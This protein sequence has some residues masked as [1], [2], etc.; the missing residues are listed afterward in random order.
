MCLLQ[1]LVVIEQRATGSWAP[2]PSR[3]PAAATLPLL[4]LTDLHAR[5]NPSYRWPRMQGWTLRWAAARA[6]AACA[7]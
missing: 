6:P 3:V 4:T 2:V 5:F 1:P 7:R